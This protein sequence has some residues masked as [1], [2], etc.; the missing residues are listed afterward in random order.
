[1]ILWLDIN[2]NIDVSL[3]PQKIGTLE[4]TMKY[5]GTTT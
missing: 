4:Q 3:F 2:G 1:M 5:Y